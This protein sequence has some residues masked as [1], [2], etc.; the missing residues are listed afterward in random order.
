MAATTARVLDAAD[1]PP[2]RDEP[3]FAGDYKA[4][5]AAFQ[6]W[7]CRERRRRKKVQLHDADA[8]DVPAGAEHEMP[9]TK[10]AKRKYRSMLPRPRREAF[11]TKADFEDAM[12]ERGAARD[13][14]RRASRA[15]A[16]I[17]RR[18]RLRKH[19]QA[20]A[21]ADRE[22]DRKR[23]ERRLAAALD[24]AAAAIP[25]ARARL[26]E[27][28]DLVLSLEELLQKASQYFD[29]CWLDKRMFQAVVAWAHANEPD[30]TDEWEDAVIAV[31]M[32]AARTRVGSWQ[33]RVG[34]HECLTMAFKNRNEGRKLHFTRWPPGA[35]EPDPDRPI[36]WRA[37]NGYCVCG[38]GPSAYA[39]DVYLNPGGGKGPVCRVHNKAAW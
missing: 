12:A 36:V 11:D 31:A 33:R 32:D 37:E 27:Q 13:V 14:R 30:G 9:N 35:L 20:A 38:C 39:P 25:I 17:E 3:R 1:P 28:Q 16:C 18:E 29:C 4:F 8:A 19:E 22:A 7:D 10:P 26:H 15:E 23:A 34:A 21:F 5:R 6:A 2:R 24:E